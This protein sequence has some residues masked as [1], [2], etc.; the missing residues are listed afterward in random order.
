ML[1]TIPLAVLAA[2][3]LGCGA[4]PAPQTDPCAEGRCG[5]SPTAPAE[6]QQAPE[7]SL[8]D[9]SEYQHLRCPKLE[10]DNPQTPMRQC[11]VRVGPMRF[12]VTEGP[13]GVVVTLIN[14]EG[15]PIDTPTRAPVEGEKTFEGQR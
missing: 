14:T 15:Q 10:G 12:A 3:T 9:A 1:R 11:R 2:L 13:N 6:G 4:P 7:R 8:K 5:S